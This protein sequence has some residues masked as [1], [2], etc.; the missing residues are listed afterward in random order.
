[1]RG[2]MLGVLLVLAAC[3]LSRISM[4]DDETSIIG[5]WHQQDLMGLEIQT[6]VQP[7]R[8]PCVRAWLKTRDLAFTAGP[9]K[10]LLGSLSIVTKAHPVGTA[11]IDPGCPYVVPGVPAASLV[12]RPN[13]WSIY[14]RGKGLS[15]WEVIATLTT[16]ESGVSPTNVTPD[17]LNAYLQPASEGGYL[18]VSRV[19]T[20]REEVPMARVRAAS[21]SDEPRN[22]ILESMIRRLTSADC[23]AAMAE[24]SNGVGDA[25]MIQ[26][27]CDLRRRAHEVLGGLVGVRILGTDD[28]DRMPAT[29]PLPGL[30]GP[31]DRTQGA[32]I[33]FIADF[34][35][36][37]S[38]AGDVLFI[39]EQNAWKIKSLWF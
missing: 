2:R 28:F 17:T 5:E 34:S 11:S 24:L 27:A 37:N 18:L 1:M 16:F 15:H 25:H 26:S 33:G 29:Y 13:M 19:Q 30:D 36:N 35:S 38:L 23:A 9:A 21:E 6:N 32:L 31:M 10:G 4:G 8:A 7:N 39:K 22:R 14:A 3:A 20:P 12:F